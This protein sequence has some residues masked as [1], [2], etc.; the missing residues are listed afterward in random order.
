M[1]TLP[2]IEH[3]TLQGIV[4]ASPITVPALAA[5]LQQ[6]Q[7]KVHAACVALG[8]RGLAELSEQPYQ[9][10]SLDSHGGGLL[11]ERVIIGALARLGGS[12]LLTDLPQ[13]TP[14]DQRA[15]GQS[16]RWLKTKRWMTQRGRELTLTDVGRAALQA[17]GPDEL[18]LDAL[19][20]LGTVRANDLQTQGVPVQGALALLDKRK[21]LIKVKERV[22]RL[23]AITAAGLA[24]W[25]DG[26]IQVRRQVNLLTSDMLQDGSWRDVDFRPYDVTL[27]TTPTHPGK[28]NPFQRV[29][30]ETRRVFL[31]LGFSEIASPF[32]ES[33]FWDFDALFQPQDHPARE[34]QDT[35]YVTRPARCRLPDA[36]YVDAVA[37]THEDGGSTGSVGWRYRFDRQ[38]AHRPVLRTH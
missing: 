16:L 3:N 12:A 5:S 11:P 31:E 9:E 8:Q 19:A 23:V 15:V 20:R 37:A 2:E 18:L 21:G 17:P 33:S 6:D 1:I 32:V 22:E 24:A 35:F 38:L 27:A 25:H 26:Q 30:A 28:I 29:L 13:H 10:I 36:S 4:T 34:M 7:S 14:L